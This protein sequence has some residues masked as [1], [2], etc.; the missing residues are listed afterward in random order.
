MNNPI[1]FR[2]MIGFAYFLITFELDL[3]INKNSISDSKSVLRL[4]IKWLL[5][6]HIVTGK[7]EIGSFR[8]NIALFEYRKHRFSLF[9]F[10]CGRFGTESTNL[11]KMLRIYSQLFALWSS[12]PNK[13][14]V[15]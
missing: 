13:E 8:Q 14:N 15:R 9:G 10:M 6:Y 1:M 5:G 12:K 11:K 3:T 7:L 2:Y 4:W